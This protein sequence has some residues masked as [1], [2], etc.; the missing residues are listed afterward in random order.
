MSEQESKYICYDS[1][2]QIGTIV[3]GLLIV[4]PTEDTRP[5]ATLLPFPEV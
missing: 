5:D 4:P 1:M 2:T 3:E